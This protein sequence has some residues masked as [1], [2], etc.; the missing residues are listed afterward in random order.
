MIKKS[1]KIF[2]T[3][4]VAGALASLILVLLFPGIYYA[5]LKLLGKKIE[6]QASIA[7]SLPLAIILNNLAASFLCSYGGFIFARI[8]LIFSGGPPKILR[9]LAFLDS[10]VASIPDE[11]LRYYLPLHIFPTFI[12]VLNGFVLGAFFIFYLQNLEKYYGGLFPHAYFELPAIILSG[13]IGLEIAGRASSSSGNLEEF[14]RELNALA[15]SRI[16]RY[17]L[18][19][20]L[21]VVG[22]V[23]ESL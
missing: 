18:V 19:V 17:C 6:T 23:V 13:S 3:G 22:G 8:F 12:L 21:L 9:K 4:F 10:T 20:A 15:K 1:L 7:R 5:F 16:L 14:K 2:L 11:R